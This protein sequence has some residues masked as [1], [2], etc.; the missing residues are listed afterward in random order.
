MS[1]VYGILARRWY[2]ADGTDLKTFHK[3]EKQ[4]AST[5]LA[6]SIPNAATADVEAGRALLS[7]VVP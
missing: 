2:L 1:M 5:A 3:F 4:G 7:S 6:G